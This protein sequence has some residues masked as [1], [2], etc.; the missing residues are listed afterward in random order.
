MQALAKLYE[1]PTF[2]RRAC[3]SMAPALKY[4]IARR[5]NAESDCEAWSLDCDPGDS[6]FRVT[7]KRR[8]WTKVRHFMDVG[9]ALRHAEANDGVV[10]ERYV[11]PTGEVNWWSLTDEDCEAILARPADERKPVDAGSKPATAAWPHES[12]GP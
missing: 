10:W 4:V 7:D 6:A 11:G 1:L 8:R 12:P 9:T 3:V 5:R 2:F